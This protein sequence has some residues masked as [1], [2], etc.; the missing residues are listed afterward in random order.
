MADESVPG[1]D[2]SPVILREDGPLLVVDKPAGVLTEGVPHHVPT[3]V[4]SV[5][6]WLVA[7]GPKPGSAYL[8]VVH[9]LDRP[10]S[11]ALAFALTS[12]AAARLAEEFREHRVAK[13]YLAVVERAPAEPT[14]ELVDW[15]AKVP[16]RAHVLVVDATAPGAREARLRYRTI[17]AVAGGAL[18]EV[19]PLTGR[20]HQIRVQ[21]ARRGW[22]IVGDTQYGATTAFP[23]VAPRDPRD[24]AIALHA[25]RLALAHPIRR[26]EVVVTSPLPAAWVG[27]GVDGNV[28]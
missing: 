1:A 22:P 18:L 13:A 4:G 16:D 7:R 19:V 14:G 21:C 8:G 10:V 23:G 5:K 27:L 2:V 11:G 26:D 20:M 17:A 25:R 9:R 6:R 15:L 24:G 3:L 28:L 12:K